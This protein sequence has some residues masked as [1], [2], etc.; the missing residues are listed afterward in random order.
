M[1]AVPRGDGPAPAVIFGAGQT[2]PALIDRLR[3]E[4]FS[5]LGL[6]DNDRAK[7][8]AQVAGLTISPPAYRD[9][10]TV[11]VSSLTHADAIVGQLHR[12]GYPSER[13]LRLR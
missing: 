13:I 5:L 1:N 6:F 11:V 2:T 8:G 4:R 12:L 7:W 9:D 10:T 3:P